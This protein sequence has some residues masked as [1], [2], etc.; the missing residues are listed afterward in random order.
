MVLAKVAVILFLAIPF[1]LIVVVCWK[2][3][4]L[5]HPKSVG[6]ASEDTRSD[7]RTLDGR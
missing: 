6:C 2:D 4:L 7:A 3:L 1:I 5:P